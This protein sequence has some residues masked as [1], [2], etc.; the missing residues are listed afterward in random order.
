MIKLGII[1]G[2]RSGEHEVSLMSAVSV[3]K[4][5][6]RNKFEPV[7]I[8]ITK[9]GQWL[10]YEGEPCYIEDG[11][12]EKTAVPFEIGHLKETIDFAFP[13]LHGPYG[14]DG[15]IQGLF[16]MLDVPYAGCGVLAS[17]VAMD[18]AIA[19]EL[20]AYNGLPVCKHVLIL[21]ETLKFGSDEA[22]CIMPEV[23][24]A[25]EKQMPYPLFVKPANMG[26]SVGISKAKDRTSLAAA[27]IQAA[28]FDRRLLVE[29]GLDCR[30]VETAIV[31]NHDIEVAVVG[32][33]LPSAEF[34]DYTA[35][36]L[37]G[38]KSRLCIPAN[39]PQKLCN[40]IRDIAAQA[41][42]A[43]D[44]TGY[45][46]IDFFLEKS[47]GKVYINEINTIPG[48]TKYSMFPLLFRESGTP[49]SRII[50][51]IVDYGYE[52]YYAKNNW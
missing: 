45:A 41:Y 50:E 28:K 27:M 26:S 16:E 24:D 8:G 39:L 23:I 34:Y 12:W 33:I 47:T 18:K 17:A 3:L 20:F 13:V 15:T 30:E 52:R 38:G 46:R 51:R 36:Y 22:E 25:I 44:C 19:K 35:K 37:D 5:L 32:E 9:S 10:Y 43:L 1:F 49:Y 4:T 11:S 31:G 29:E 14:E 42:R 21:S 2:G 48:F 7:T 40:R 6:N